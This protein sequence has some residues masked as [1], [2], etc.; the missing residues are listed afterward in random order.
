MI[1][2]KWR[3]G[4]KGLKIADLRG[5]PLVRGLASCL[6]TAGLRP[7][8]RTGLSPVDSWH[9]A[10]PRAS[11]DWNAEDAD[12]G[13][14]T[15]I[16]FDPLRGYVFL[17]RMNRIN[18]MKSGITLLKSAQIRVI[19]VIRVPI[20]QHAPPPKKI[21]PLRGYYKTLNGFTPDLLKRVK[22]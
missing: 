9:E 8:F 1:D 14:W 18:R 21:D 19:R 4:G 5:D 17:D 13:G 3:D 12:L 11:R 10:K 2:A 7:D 15:R 6:V 22:E 20:P 16:F